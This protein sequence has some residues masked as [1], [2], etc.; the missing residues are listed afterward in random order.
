M[1]L[2]D[3][4]EWTENGLKLL[5]KI[6]SIIAENGGRDAMI[7]IMEA[8]AGNTYL[9]ERSKEKEVF[10]LTI[11]H[12]IPYIVAHRMLNMDYRKFARKITEYKTKELCGTS[13]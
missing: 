2:K 11:K 8:E 6:Q 10:K 4:F 1:T 9:S 5:E 12:D 7:E 3:Q 13:L